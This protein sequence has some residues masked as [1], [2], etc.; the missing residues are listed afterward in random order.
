MDEVNENTG[1]FPGDDNK[2][3]AVMDPSQ[4][5]PTPDQIRK[6]QEQAL[7]FEKYLDESGLSLS[8]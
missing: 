7:M 4:E 3:L 6:R 1:D 5:N 8:F 2:Q